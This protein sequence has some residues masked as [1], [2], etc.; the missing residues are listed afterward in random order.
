MVFCTLVL[1]FYWNN[2][3]NKQRR[4]HIFEEKTEGKQKSVTLMISVDGK[5]DSCSSEVEIRWGIVRIK[6]LKNRILKN[7]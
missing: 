3:Q 7:S 5:K 2:G 6:V 4:W 1:Q